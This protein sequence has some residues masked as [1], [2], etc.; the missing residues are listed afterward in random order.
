MKIERL[1]AAE[2]PSESA[3][4][5]QSRT[6]LGSLPFLSLWETVGG[7]VVVWVMRDEGEIVAMLPGVEFRRAPFTRFQ[8]APDGV[9]L[10]IIR[11]EQTRTRLD[12]QEQLLEGVL[13]HGYAKVFLTDYFRELGEMV[14]MSVE[15]RSSRVI[16]L[17]EGWEPPDGTVRSEIRK[18]ERE[19]VRVERF[20]TGKHMEGFLALMQA[21]ETRH[22]REAKYPDNFFRALA[23][24]AAKDERVLWTYVSHEGAPVASHIYLIENETALN[25]QIYF[26][27][28]FSSLKANQLMTF[29]AAREL[30]AAGVRYLGL[31]GTPPDA[32]GVETYKEKWGGQSVAYPC[33][34]RKSLLGR[35]L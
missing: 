7:Q 26:D 30:H 25:W 33:F 20:D 9:Y 32:E 28:R 10:R 34:V 22:G 5:L 27:K 14:R 4:I 13:A 8:A 29:S 16:E 31:G 19:G 17:R 2:L 12:S 15:M 18:A 23:E 6:V 35:I 21:T 1:M 24:V 11:P 3:A